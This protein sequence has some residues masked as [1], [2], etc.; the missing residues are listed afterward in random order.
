MKDNTVTM[1]WGIL[2]RMEQAVARVRERLLR[3]TSALNRAEIPYAVVGGH[4]VASWVAKIDDGAVRTTL[5]VDILV[6]RQ[7]Q[8][9][10]ADALGH[11][12]FKPREIG[13][14]SVFLDGA[15]RS[16]RDAVHL[17]WSGEKI[18]PDHLLPTPDIDAV[19]DPSGYHVLDL[20]PLAVM[21]LVAS[22]NKDAMHVRDLIDV[23]LIDA[24]WLAKLPP[25]LAA[26]LK[27]ILDTPGG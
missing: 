20:E 1:G 17:V 18:K 27:Q 9:A 25:V 15:G 4:A 6:R 16:P 21:K 5:D 13:D 11:A 10:I 3:A 22:R 19:D 26:R 23:G 24:S 2:D 8:Q 14:G 12:G 7:D